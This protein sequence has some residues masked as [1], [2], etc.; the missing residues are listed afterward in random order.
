[1]EE[2]RILMPAVRKTQELKGIVVAIAVVVAAIVATILGLVAYS[3]SA[4]DQMS[5]ESETRLV[6]RAAERALAKTQE[7]VTS[8]AIWTDAYRALGSRDMEWLQTNFGD[9]YADFMGHDVTIAYGEDTAPV[10]ASRSSEPVAIADEAGFI[11]AVKPL[12]DGVRRDSLRPPNTKPSST[13]FDI[14]S[15]R[16]AVVQSGG[17]LYFVAASTVV[18][19]MAADAT[20]G[21]RFGIVVSARK[22]SRVLAALR[23]DLGI[24]GA[25]IT[26]PGVA[27]DPR[28]P[29]LGANGE[30]LGG[31]TWTLDQPGA[32]VLRNAGPMLALIAAILALVSALLVVRVVR[33]LGSL[34][35]KRQ[36][37]AQSMKDLEAARDA[38]EQANVA[39]SQFLASMSHE[40]RTPLNGIL[41]MAQSLK[42]AGSLSRDDAD[43]VSVIL[44]SGESLTA[45]L[46]DVLDL[47]KIEA[48]KLEIA[49]V[50]TNLAALAE[51]A[52][53]LFE[54]L[55]HDKGL[56]LDFSRSGLPESTL[57]VD[58]VHIQ[59]CISNLVSNAIKFTPSG[60]VG[61]A[62]RAERATDGRFNVSIAVRDTGIGMSA[63]TIGKLFSNFTQADASTTRNF[64]GSGLGLAIS[65]R[66][67]RLMDGDV[68]VE[69]EPGKGST[70]TLHFTAQLG[71]EQSATQID[72]TTPATT[73]SHLGA[74]VLI[75][76]DNSVNRQ[77]ARLFL[78]S[79]GLDLHEAHN[80]LEALDRL[81][82]QSFDLVLLD[83]HMPVMDGRECI[84][85]IRTSETAWRDIPVI[86]LTAEAMS[87]DRER[88]LALGMTDY[89]PKPINRAELIAKVTR[90]LGSDDAQSVNRSGVTADESAPDLSSVLADIDAMIA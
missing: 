48:G 26:G 49:T 77:V 16:Q 23:D 36:R 6:T 85:R 54:P 61:I 51:Q 69:S 45:L 40:I 87:G 53:R 89:L 79:L 90:H 47:S 41:G 57:K 12:V 71:A 28:V 86:A 50:D 55:A 14:V 84:R 46:N 63:E 73:A 39:K 15:A 34:S 58:P 38:A 3:A 33:I 7:D 35:R 5:R 32:Q 65:R 37:L 88:L 75:V 52:V 10:Y 1:M 66:L 72:D 30:D 44:T 43:K 17:E 22:A 2:Q 21:G 11:A 8:A 74:R 25:S 13:G 64:G 68:T 42:E 78:A 56:H 9:Y 80:G 83:V 59:Q 82:A 62:L 70:F 31:L 29:L 67:A 60:E 20:P 4:V 24:Q 19:E 81:A 18:P 76:D 27:T